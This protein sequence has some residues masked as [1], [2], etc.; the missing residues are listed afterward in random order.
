MGFISRDDKGFLWVDDRREREA[1]PPG[2]PRSIRYYEP[3]LIRDPRQ[4]L[5]ESVPRAVGVAALTCPTCGGRGILLAGDAAY[6]LD[7]AQQT[8]R[9]AKLKVVPEERPK[10]RPIERVDWTD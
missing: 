6:S 5:Q 8:G 2:E 9:T 7:R 10:P 1:V 4:T 3:F